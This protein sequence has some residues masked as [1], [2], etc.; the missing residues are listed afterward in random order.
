MSL[1]SYSVHNHVKAQ[2]V[3]ATS[4]MVVH[5]VN[6]MLREVLMGALFATLVIVLFLRNFRS[7]LIAVVS[8]PLSLGLTLFLLW[9]SGITLNILTLGGVAVAVGRLVD[10]SIVVVENIFRRTAK[11]GFSAGTI[12]NATGEVGKAITAST[13]TTI[14]VFLPMGL[15]HGTLRQ[16][17]LPFALTVTYSLLASL[18]VAL[19]VVPLMSA[20]L[21]KSSNLPAH[22]ESRFYKRVLRWSLNHKFVPIL[23]AVVVFFGSIALYMAMP[24]GAM[25]ASDASMV[26]VSMTYPSDTPTSK[27]KHKANAFE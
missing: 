13:L 1:Y 19:T 14:A 18:L 26:S 15:I 3:Y 5:S 12:M 4:N 22:K 10:D 2:V 8:I 21:L 9:K 7:T 24:K 20:W 27:I 23:T 16:F 17:M 11:S 6:S 25:S